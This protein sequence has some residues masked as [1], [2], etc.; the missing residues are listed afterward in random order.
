MKHQLTVKWGEK[1]QS[2]MNS[3]CGVCAHGCEVIQEFVRE[4]GMVE[5]IGYRNGELLHYTAGSTDC[6]PFACERV[7]VQEALRWWA[8]LQSDQEADSASWAEEARARFL[9]DAAACLPV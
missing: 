5:G 8:S 7:T 1:M 9:R 4:N 3:S 2:I 6:S